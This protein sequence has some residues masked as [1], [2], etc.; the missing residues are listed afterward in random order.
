MKKFLFW[1]IML[2]IFSINLVNAENL[3]DLGE[4]IIEF[5]QESGYN[6]QGF[7]VVN[8]YLFAVLID[9]ND[10][11][12]QII[13]YNL[14]TY[15]LDKSYKYSSLGHANDVTYNKNNNLIYILEA[16]GSKIINVFDGKTFLFKEQIETSIP[17]RSITYIEDY[18]WYAGRMV[19]AGYKFDNNFN[20]VSNIPFILGMNLKNDIGRQGWSYYNEHIYYSNWSWVRFGG[21]GANIIYVYDL[22]GN[23]VD[24]Y[25]T[26][27][28][29][30]E[31]ED[32][33]FYNDKM[34]LGFNGYDGINRFYL[35]NIPDI[36]VKKTKENVQ[37]EI[38]K[39]DTSIYWIG[40]IIA[41]LVGSI[42][43]INLKRRVNLR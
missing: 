8:N 18:D 29:I 31:I 35:S 40:I 19:T 12:S 4:P 14:N 3:L 38:V 30:G 39:K 7:T 33:A 1:I 36:V 28:N 25:Y 34:I 37:E 27:N 26:K 32:I 24:Y 17:L 23:R 20:L 5:P 22:K 9:D 16:G 15:K 6:L 13:V 2:F 42:I 21:D 11:N 41:I 10:T 43:F